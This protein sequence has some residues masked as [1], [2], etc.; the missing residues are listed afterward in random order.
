MIAG[1]PSL[2]SLPKNDGAQ[3]KV[4]AFTIASCHFVLRQRSANV[5]F[6]LER[7]KPQKMAYLLDFSRPIQNSQ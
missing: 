1:L 2:V 3:R 7:N 6:R 5:L 4:L